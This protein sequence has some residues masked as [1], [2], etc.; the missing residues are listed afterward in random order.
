VPHRVGRFHAAGVNELEIEDRPAADWKLAGLALFGRPLEGRAAGSK[1]QHRP[2]RDEV[3]LRPRRA[4]LRP[5]RLW[6]MDWSVPKSLKVNG[7][8]KDRVARIWSRAGALTRGPSRRKQVQQ[9]KK[10]VLS[11]GI[12]RTWRKGSPDQR[13]ALP[14]HWSP[15]PI[16]FQCD[17]SNRR[18]QGKAIHRHTR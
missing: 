11:A 3:E 5:L 4:S 13:P 2:P 12:G 1:G 14:A 8:C 7:L 10:P 16:S 6:S 9:I 18:T 15:G 17:R